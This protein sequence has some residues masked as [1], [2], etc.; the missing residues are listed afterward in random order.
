MPSL[1]HLLLNFLEL[2]PKQL[3]N[4]ASRSSR[5]T[6]RRATTISSTSSMPRIRRRCSRSPSGTPPSVWGGFKVCRPSTQRASK[7]RSRTQRAERA[8]AHSLASW[9]PPFA[10]DARL[11]FGAESPLDHLVGISGGISSPIAFVVFEAAR[12][13]NAG[14]AKI[15]FTVRVSLPRPL[16]PAMKICDRDRVLITPSCGNRIFGQNNAA[17]P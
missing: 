15:V 12:E 10:G 8:L 7:Q 17:T 5:S 6:T 9:G 14:A 16:T 3:E 11:L 13:R 1:P 4:W 2:R